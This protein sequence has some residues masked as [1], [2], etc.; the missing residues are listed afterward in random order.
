MPLR[1]HITW[2]R[3]KEKKYWAYKSL[4][5][6][7]STIPKVGAPLWYTVCASWL[8]SLP[9][10]LEN[11]QTPPVFKTESITAFRRKLWK[12]FTSWQSQFGTQHCS[13]CAKAVGTTVQGERY[14]WEPAHTCDASD[15]ASF[16]LLCFHKA[17]SVLSVN[18]TLF[19]G[20]FFKSQPLNELNFF[21]IRDL[22]MF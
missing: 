8:I 17:L 10:S 2:D 12:Q 3:R 4:Q 20:N 22:V 11:Q 9:Q 14:I 15:I 7:D 16:L 6:M 13:H 18:L 19:R 1:L 21:I 5:K